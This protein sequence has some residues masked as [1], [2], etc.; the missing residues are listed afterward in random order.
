VHEAEIKELRTLKCSYTIQASKAENRSEVE[1]PARM[2]PARRML[3]SL[4]SLVRHDSE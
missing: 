3:K 2:R 1:M 4:K